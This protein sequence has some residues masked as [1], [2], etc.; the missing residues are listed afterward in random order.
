[1]M[2]IS[3]SNPMFY[4]LVDRFDEEIR[5]AVL[6]EVNFMHLILSSVILHS[7][8]SENRTPKKHTRLFFFFKHNSLL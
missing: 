5:Q 1:M 2:H 4:H 6:I 8:T 7:K 3:S